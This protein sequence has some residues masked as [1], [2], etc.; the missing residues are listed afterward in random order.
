MTDI[1]Q[2][3]RSPRLATVTV[4]HTCARSGCCCSM[5]A[6]LASLSYFFGLY[7]TSH[8]SFI[9]AVDIHNSHSHVTGILFALCVIIR[10]FLFL[11]LSLYMYSGQQL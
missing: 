9:G 6:V 5:I 4:E 10:L 7:S 1:Q 11:F 3:G 8:Q 2:A